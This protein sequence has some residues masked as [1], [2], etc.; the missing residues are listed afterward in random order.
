MLSGARRARAFY[1]NWKQ[2]AKGFWESLEIR[3]LHRL[4]AVSLFSWSIEENARDTQ[5]T[6]RETEGA[7]RERHEKRLN[8]TKKRDS[9]Q[10]SCCRLREYW[11]LIW[12]RGSDAMHD[13]YVTA[14][15]VC[16]GQVKRSTWYRGQPPGVPPVGRIE[17]SR[18]QSFQ[19]QTKIDVSFVA[20]HHG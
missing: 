7:R 14:K 13:G 10:S 19:G 11:P 2:E 16:L 6:T 5:T 3:F 18:S 12:L 4:R 17:N 8:L 20:E 1:R 15:Q 9:S